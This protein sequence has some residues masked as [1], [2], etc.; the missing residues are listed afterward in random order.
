MKKSSNHTKSL[1]GFVFA[2]IARKNDVPQMYLIEAPT[3]AD[4]LDPQ[5]WGISPNPISSFL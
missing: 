5:A 2:A 3:Q 1:S 4:R